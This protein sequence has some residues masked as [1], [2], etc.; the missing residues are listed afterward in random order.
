MIN[1]TFFRKSPFVTGVTSAI[2][3]V[4]FLSV[5]CAGEPVSWEE[6]PFD[7][8]R[9][10]KS[11]TYDPNGPDVNEPFFAM[12]LQWAAEDSLGTWSGNDVLAYADA[13]G[14]SSK[15]PL[16]ELVSFSRNR[17]T[18]ADEGIWPDMKVKAIWDIELVSDLTPPMP[19][20][21]LGY[22]P[23]TLHVSGRIRMAEVHLGSVELTKEDGSVKVSDIQLFRLE[24]GI[25]ILDV[26]GWLDALLGKRLDDA[27]ML[28]F[29]S[30]REDGRLIGLALSIGS[31]GRPIYGELDF[32]QDKV[33]ANGRAVASAL[34]AACRSIFILGMDDPVARAWGR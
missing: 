22:H 1:M 33:L 16:E 32:Q 25:L 19:Y 21:I 6:D 15:F 13:L 20:S 2:F 11:Y 17:P 9:A 34:S 7:F 23:G 29:V 8:S 28:G 30:A 26:D 4:L 24:T 3:V 31:K 18:K 27:A 5:A 12:V 10:D 14:R